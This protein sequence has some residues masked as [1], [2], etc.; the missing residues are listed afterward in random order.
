MRPQEISISVVSSISV[1]SSKDWD[2]C[3]VDSTGPERFNPLITH[4]FLSSLEESGS[5]VKVSTLAITCLS[6]PFISTI[7]HKLL[8]PTIGV[9]SCCFAPSA[10]HNVSRSSDYLNFI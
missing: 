9:P 3:C 5:A 8:E 2:A 10:E 1:I 6:Y 7:Y 4:A